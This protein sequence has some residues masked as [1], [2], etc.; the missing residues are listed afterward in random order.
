MSSFIGAFANILLQLDTV[1]EARVDHL[2][3]IVA[4]V[5]RYFPTLWPKQQQAHY[6]AL[7]RLLIALYSKGSSL[8]M[9]LSRVCTSAVAVVDEGVYQRRRRFEMLSASLILRVQSSKELHTR[10][11]GHQLR[12]EWTT[13]SSGS[14][15]TLISGSTC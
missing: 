9:L 3:R 5:F 13:L 1:D 15:D 7:S 12:W 2:E 6:Y 14:S 10:V 11:L 4:A 8:K